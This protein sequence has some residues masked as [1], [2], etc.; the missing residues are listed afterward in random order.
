MNWNDFAVGIICVPNAE[1]FPGV[2]R[3]EHMR[4]QLK[5]IGLDDEKDVFWVRTCDIR[6][7]ASERYV[8]LAARS[9]FFQQPG[10]Y[11][12]KGAPFFVGGD[13]F[14]GDWETAAEARAKDESKIRGK[15]KLDAFINGNFRRLLPLL[16]SSCPDADPNQMPEDPEFY[17]RVLGEN[18]ATRSNAIE[19]LLC[20]RSKLART[21]CSLS[22][23]RGLGAIVSSTG[24][25]G[26]VRSGSV[27][28][29]ARFLLMLEDDVVFYKGFLG[30]LAEIV[31][32]LKRMEERWSLVQ[33]NYST[34]DGD[35]RPIEIEGRVSVLLRTP[36]SGYF[37]HS[38]ILY[39]LDG[40]GVEAVYELYQGCFED[41]NS[42]LRAQDEILKTMGYDAL[43]NTMFVTRQRFVA[44]PLEDHSSNVCFSSMNY[45]HCCNDEGVVEEEKV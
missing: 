36:P 8:D 3:E 14:V 31:E 15:A 7:A 28:R 21:A 13:A 26:D 38:A 16:L 39:D 5:N 18:G 24:G 12:K 40:G 45:K 37:G 30:Q 29:K 42:V 44:P 1:I 20:V 10:L 23:S 43:K 27:N 33:L 34:H 4:R 6:E 9:D 22:H 25:G 11:K 41:E 2:T 35:A 19:V 17:A 32:E